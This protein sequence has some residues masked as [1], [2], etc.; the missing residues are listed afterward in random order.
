MR[1]MRTWQIEISPEECE[2]LLVNSLLG[3]LGVVVDGRPEIYP[4]NHVYDLENGVVVFPTNAGTKL[5]GALDWPYVSFE[6]DGLDE[7]GGWSVLV[8]G[9]AEELTH[10]DDIRRLAAL[11]DVLWRSSGPLHWVRIVPTRVTGRRITTT[12][13]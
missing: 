2:K 8:V 4:V 11:R 7:H 1:T 5:H 6:V 12:T 10:P 13:G 9:R 3:R